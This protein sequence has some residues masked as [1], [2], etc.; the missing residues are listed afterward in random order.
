[1]SASKKTPDP[2]F[3][4]FQLLAWWPEDGDD[5]RFRRYVERWE[6]RAERLSRKMG[7]HYDP[8]AI[9]PEVTGIIG[10]LMGASDRWRWSGQSK[11]SRPPCRCD[12]CKK[13]GV[14]TIC[15]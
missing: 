5:G 9:E 15:H 12:G 8:K 14:V 1:M 7:F 6:V 2:K 13:N 11:D 10:T 3:P 4:I